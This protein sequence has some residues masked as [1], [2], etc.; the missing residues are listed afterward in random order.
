MEGHRHYSGIARETGVADQNLQHFM[1]NS[2]WSAEAVY[3]QVQE[4]VKAVPGLTQ[5]AVVLIDESA[6]EKAG[7]VSAGAAKH[8]NGRL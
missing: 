1:S 5:G 6:D 7:D 3:R 8:Y 4:E 2:P